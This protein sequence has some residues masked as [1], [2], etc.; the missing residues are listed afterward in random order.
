MLKTVAHR[1]LP[2][3]LLACILPGFSLAGQAIKKTVAIPGC[4]HPSITLNLPA[5]KFEMGSSNLSINKLE[6]GS[7][8]LVKINAFTS[9][10]VETTRARYLEFFRD[11]S[12]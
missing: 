3:V 6:Q 8:R 11:V 7:V 9:S 2:L 1:N 5:V 10:I 12:S 4:L